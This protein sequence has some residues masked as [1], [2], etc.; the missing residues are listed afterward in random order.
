MI[1]KEQINKIINTISLKNFIHKYISLE[2]VGNNYRGFSPFNQENHP[3]FMVSEKK[4]I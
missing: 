1:L 3:S 4:K 2:K